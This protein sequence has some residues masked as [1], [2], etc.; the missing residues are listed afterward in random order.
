MEK[1][2]T[3]LR[4][5]LIGHPVAQSKSPIVQNYWLT[6]QGVTGS[7]EAVDV[8]PSELADFVERF[9][10]TGFGAVPM[11]PS[12]QAVDYFST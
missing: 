9:L 10:R 11:L 2:S 7:Y 12:A 8:A 1:S 3:P 6:K 5:G 4:A